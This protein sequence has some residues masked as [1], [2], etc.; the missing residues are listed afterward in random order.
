MKVF[1][2]IKMKPH[3][4]KSQNNSGKADNITSV[5]VS[6]YFGLLQDLS[7]SVMIVIQTDFYSNLGLKPSG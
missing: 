5:P 2:S 4:L 7:R 1:N 3:A 6:I